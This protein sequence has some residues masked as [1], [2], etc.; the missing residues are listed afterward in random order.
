MHLHLLFIMKISR[1]L[2]QR[3]KLKVVHVYMQC[4]YKYQI[5]VKI[6]KSIIK[7]KNINKQN[8]YS[9]LI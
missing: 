4:A 9:F 3:I 5:D 1:A 6:K 7:K 8:L 2:H